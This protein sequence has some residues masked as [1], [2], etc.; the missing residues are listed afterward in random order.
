MIYRSLAFHTRRSPRFDPTS[1]SKRKLPRY[2]PPLLQR[3]Y[4]GVFGPPLPSLPVTFASV[5]PSCHGASMQPTGC[6]LHLGLP[7]FTD[8]GFSVRSPVDSL[9]AS[10]PQ[11]TGHEV[12]PLALRQASEPPPSALAHMSTWVFGVRRKR[13]GFPRGMFFHAL[14]R[15]PREYLSR[16]MRTPP[17]PQNSTAC[18]RVRVRSGSLLC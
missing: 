1:T 16:E 2:S 10:R 15:Y 12:S 6:W 14:K 8:Y 18:G 3:S 5:G 17:F 7:F 4:F 13:R 9:V 11:V